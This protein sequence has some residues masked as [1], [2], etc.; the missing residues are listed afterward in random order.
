[1]AEESKELQVGVESIEKLTR[2]SEAEVSKIGRIEADFH[3]TFRRTNNGNFEG[4]KSSGKIGYIENKE[5][6]NNILEYFVQNMPP[7]YKIEEI[8]NSKSIELLEQISKNDGL[9]EIFLKPEVQTIMNLNAQ[10]AK[11]LIANYK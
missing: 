10:Y 6:K 5:L 7:L 11:A 4:F 1:M 8:R 2:L 9:A 3:L